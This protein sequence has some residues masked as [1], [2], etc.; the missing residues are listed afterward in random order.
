MLAR[1]VCTHGWA[2]CLARISYDLLP[3]AFAIAYV[4]ERSNTLMRAAIT[5]AMIAWSF[6]YNLVPAAGPAYAFHLFPW[7]NEV[8]P[9]NIPGPRNCF[10]SLHLGWALII[11]LNV[12]SKYL[13]AG[14]WIFLGLTVYS[15]IGLGEHYYVDLIVAVPFVLG[16]QK[17]AEMME[18]REMQKA[19]SLFLPLLFFCVTLT[20]PARLP[21]STR[22]C[23]PN[24]SSI[25][26]DHDE[27]FEL[28]LLPQSNAS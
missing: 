26:I 16:V 20:R 1:Y 8:L 25:T 28:P 27:L 4:C 24:I 23:P 22:C 12:K 19:R 5:A 13:K 17:L 10:P 15:T 7:T 2:L 21:P 9:A 18:K 14:A 3:L 6:G 11:F